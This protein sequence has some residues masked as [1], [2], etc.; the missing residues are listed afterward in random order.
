MFPVIVLLIEPDGLARKPAMVFVR[1][2]RSIR[3]EGP[4]GLA[5]LS[6]VRGVL[7][8]GQDMLP[9]GLR[10]LRSLQESIAPQLILEEP[11]AT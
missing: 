1:L 3:E 8:Q 5:D 11:S 6:E 9:L 10:Q 7:R 2:I 4:Q